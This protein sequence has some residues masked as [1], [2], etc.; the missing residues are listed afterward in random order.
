L[1]HASDLTVVTMPEIDRSG[2]ERCLEG[3]IERLR[4]AAW[5]HVSLDLDVV[6]PRIAPGVG[7]PV[8]AASGSAR[9]TWPWRC[10]MTP[11]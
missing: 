9:P 6:D 2:L 8:P 3:A 4:P 11:G 5:V 7:T 1:I 10:S